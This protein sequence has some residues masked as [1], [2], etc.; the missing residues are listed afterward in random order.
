MALIGLKIL[1]ISGIYKNCTGRVDFEMEL[2]LTRVRVE[3]VVDENY[4]YSKTAV[5]KGFE[6]RI[7]GE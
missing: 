5:L 7:L 4:N 2:H 3:C 1:V 6:Y